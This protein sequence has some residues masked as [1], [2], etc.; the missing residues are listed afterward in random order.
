MFEKSSF[1]W[2]A[3][4]AAL[5][6]LASTVQAVTIEYVPVGDA[7]NVD[8][9]YGNGYGGV[10]YVY[11]IGKYEVT[12]AQYTEFLN[13]VAAADPN[14]L[15]NTGMGGGWNNI[16]GI[17][18]SGSG[19]EADP[20][21][22]SVRPT[23]GQRPVNYVSWYDTLRFANWLHNGQP[24]LGSPVPQND[25]STE[26]GTYDMSQGSS[27]IRKPAALVFLPSEDEWYKAAYYKGGGTNAGYWDYPTESDTAPTAELPPGADMINGSANYHD[28][29]Y[30]DTTCYT[31]EVGAYNATD[32]LSEYVSDSAY[33]TFDQGGNL[34]EW[35]EADMLGD[36]LYRG[37]RGGSFIYFSFNN[38]HA[39]TRD[40]S[41]PTNENC[42]IGF[43]VASIPEPGSITLL[44]CGAAA[45][46]A[47]I[48]AA[49]FPTRAL[50]NRRK[51]GV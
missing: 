13:A 43:R 20:W 48:G 40:I 50:R 47:A 37:S 35:N 25:D 36:G 4:V 49:A 32:A 8:D 39:S 9:T 7:G 33:G 10:S 31:T 12:N 27:V 14:G 29:G 11:N 21:A 51:H 41:Y 28:E 24:G 1:G 44:V 42:Y 30:L 6:L 38:L 23:R 2:L 46:V 18:R 34:W 3:T 26:D 19:T 17:S 15:Y 22:Y 5:L 45:C 16:G